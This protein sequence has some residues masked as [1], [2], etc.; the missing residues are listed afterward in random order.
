M[1]RLMQAPEGAGLDG[2]VLRGTG[3]SRGR[4]TGPAHLAQPAHAPPDVRPGTVL[5]A[6]LV[7]EAWTPIFPLLGGI[8]LD[9]G[10][11]FQHAAVVAREY[12][13]P[14]VMMTREATKVIA[15]GQVVTVDGDAGIVELTA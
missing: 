9:L 4:A 5:V 1:A 12:G 11:I 14:A 2:A 8:V 3:V 7:G 15:E 6:T 10:G 13:I